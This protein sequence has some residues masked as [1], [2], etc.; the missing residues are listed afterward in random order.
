MCK[1]ILP[2]FVFVYHMYAQ[3]SQKSASDALKQV[4]DSCE[5][6]CGCWNSSPL[7]EQPVL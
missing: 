4:R 6:L 2:A 1:Y 5:R 7:Q 3:E